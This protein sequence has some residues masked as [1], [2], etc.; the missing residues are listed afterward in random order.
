MRVVSSMH[1]GS[2]NH[3][4]GADDD[5]DGHDVHGMRVV[6]ILAIAVAITRC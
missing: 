1:R 2:N 3:D 6:A 5:V 4:G